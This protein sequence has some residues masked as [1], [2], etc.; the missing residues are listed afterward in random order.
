MNH[1]LPDGALCS[2]FDRLSQVYVTMVQAW[3]TLWLY[4]HRFTER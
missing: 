3:L 2:S 1:G 4:E